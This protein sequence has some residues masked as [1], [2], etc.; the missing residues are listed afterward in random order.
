MAT[1]S[2]ILALE[3][4]WTEEPGGIQFTGSQRVRHDLVNNTCTQIYRSFFQFIAHSPLFYTSPHPK[5]IIWI[6]VSHLVNHWITAFKW[7]HL[8]TWNNN[9]WS[10]ACSLESE[11]V[12]CSVMSHSL[13]PLD[14][15]GLLSMVFSRQDCCSGLSFPSPGDLP[16]PGTE[17]VAPVSPALQGNSLPV[18]LIIFFSLIS[19]CSFLWLYITV[20]H[21]KSKR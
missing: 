17:P 21:F 15:Q 7:N 20:F 14:C 1:H 6:P 8:H 5:I 9:N 12:S 10:L 11:S 19:N 16:G 13:K 4:P 3:I 18:P 2:S